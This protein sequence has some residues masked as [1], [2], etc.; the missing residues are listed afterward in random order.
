[1]IRSIL[2]SKCRVVLVIATIG[3]AA[4]AAR[5]GE[6][7]E[8]ARL[9]AANTAAVE[10][11][12]TLQCQVTIKNSPWSIPGGEYWRVGDCIRLHWV[13]KGTVNRVV[14]RDGIARFLTRQ[15]IAGNPEMKGSHEV[16]QSLEDDRYFWHGAVQR[17]EGRSVSPFDPWRMAECSISDGGKAGNVSFAQFA[18]NH[19]KEL[20]SIQRVIE[21]GVTTVAV[22]F[23]LADSTCTIHLDPAVNYMIRRR[24]S[25]NDSDEG[26]HS[27]AD[28]TRFKEAAPGVYFPEEVV[29][30][31][32]DRGQDK[33]DET[34]SFQNVVVNRPIPSTMF[35]LKFRPGIYVR[36]RIEGTKYQVNEAG[37]PAGPKEQL[38]PVVTVLPGVEP[39]TP[40]RE[41]PRA[42]G[43]WILPSSAAVLCLAGTLWYV[44]RRKGLSGA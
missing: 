15:D 23:K 40:T 43:W 3:S 9:C 41:E 36:D 4:T 12:R 30:K 37:T 10:S 27:S 21:N 11:I 8:L 22:K 29:L 6:R 24:C 18:R 44:R 39:Q 16:R 7:D 14:I 20:R 34:F 13:Q 42:S 19:E 28:V 35:D 5:A 2:W 33:P 31:R 32:R 1:M 25:R 38:M 17:S 26:Y